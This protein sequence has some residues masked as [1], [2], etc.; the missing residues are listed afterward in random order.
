MTE[1]I[2]R[3]LTRLSEAGD[4]A[5]LPGELAAP[6][7]GPVFDRLLAK[8]VLV[9]QAPLSD[10]DVCY[11]CEC[12]L[13]CRPIRK[14]GDAFRAECPL[15]RRRDVILTENDL[16]SFRMNRNS[17][18]R[19]IGGAAGFS[20][21]PSEIL[22]GVWHLGS[23]PSARAIFLVLA[24]HAL[25]REE[26][27]WAVRAAARSMPVTLL[28]PVLS[29]TEAL[30]F[31]EDEFYLVAT[32][33]CLE[34]AADGAL[35]AVDASMFNPVQAC[36]ARLVVHQAARSVIL[37]GQIKALSAQ[38]FD[39]LLILSSAA[40]ESPATVENRQIEKKL[41]GDGV[42]RIS[43]EVREPVRA[44]RDALAEGSSD[45]KNV[46]RLIENRRKPNGYRLMLL[47]DEI[48]L[49]L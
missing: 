15:D 21:E 4:D 26:L 34:L 40:L 20:T 8:R 19:E 30:R 17:L 7:F 42:H 38:S 39:L 25:L 33:E 28:A 6:F 29:P 47:P 45:P 46:R 24:R 5:I 1:T 18:A 12:G 9:E 27:G 37:D 14:A 16:R 49:V 48:E 2:L 43:S 32:F 22:D 23:T 44:L 41:W 35:L 36:R 11:D 3:L 13:P 31:R 10:W